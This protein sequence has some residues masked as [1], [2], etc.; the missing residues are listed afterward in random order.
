MATAAMVLITPAEFGGWASGVVIVLGAM[1]KVAQAIG[2]AVGGVMATKA[3]ERR[4]D[5]TFIIERQD[6]ELE[7]LRHD[8]ATIRKEGQEK[9]DAAERDCAIRIKQVEDRCE[10]QEMEVRVMKQVL[11]GMGYR[12]EGNGDW[13]PPPRGRTR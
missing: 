1:L 5:L 2:K 6:A 13:S 7:N 3:T 10:E 8:V 4:T 11:Y 9:L 12:Q